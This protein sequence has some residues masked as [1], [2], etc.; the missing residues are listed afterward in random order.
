MSQPTFSSQRIIYA[1]E[2]GDPGGR[3][4]L[5]RILC[6]AIFLVYPSSWTVTHSMDLA[7]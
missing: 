7:L 4:T 6:R 2:Y 1:A 5:I 3:H